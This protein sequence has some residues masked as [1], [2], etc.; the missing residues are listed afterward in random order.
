MVAMKAVTS[1][2]LKVDATVKAGSISS[3]PANVSQQQ[4]HERQ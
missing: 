1:I 4:H 2:L 3:N